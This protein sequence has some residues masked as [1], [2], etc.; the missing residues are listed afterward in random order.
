[1]SNVKFLHTY[2]LGVNISELYLI[3]IAL[4]D[5]VEKFKEVRKHISDHDSASGRIFDEKLSEMEAML[6]RFKMI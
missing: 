1:M 2:D 5:R 4:E 6:E 3:I